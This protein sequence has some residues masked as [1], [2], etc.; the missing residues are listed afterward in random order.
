MAGFKFNLT[1]RDVPAVNTKYRTI[2]TQIPVPESLEIFEKIDKYESTAMHGQMPVVWDR[3]S[4]F[5]VHDA[6]G[7]TWIDF[8]ST[9][10]VTNAGHSNPRILKAIQ[11]VIDKPLLHTYTYASKERAD[12]L[13]YLIEQTPP[14]FQKAFFLSAGTE[15]TE[16]GLKLMREYANKTEKRKPGVVCFEGNWHGRTM[17]AQMMGWNPA[18]KEWIGHQDPNIYHLPFPYPWRKDAMADPAAY[19]RNGMDTLIKVH[20]LDPKLDLCGFMMETFQG[21]GAVFYPPEFVQE[22]ERFA[23]EHDMLLAFDEMQAGFGRT[24][25]LFGYQ[26]YGVEADILCCGKGAGS[27]VPLS[28][29]LSNTKVM[30]LFAIGSMSS[31]HSANPMVCAVGKANL[32]ALIED[33][34]IEN[35]KKLGKL[36]HD[37]LNAIKTR[38][39]EHISWIQGKG[40]VAAVIFNDPEGNPLASLCD[41]IC[42]FGMHRGLLTVHTGRESIKLAPPLSINEEAL[43]EGLATFESC[44]ADSI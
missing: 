33:G 23:R 38:F 12:Y 17:G 4:D 21:W 44:I 37:R 42:E 10:F 15:A 26:H 39:P 36:F 6:W 2:Q 25:K 41:K 32:E 5:Q 30:D 8:T 18:Q 1:P 34:L 7:N 3:A 19:F 27:G 29:V 20:G 43:L 22:V 31:T 28:I 13:E 9:I 40:L 11:D 14:Q 24:G 35:S 16:C